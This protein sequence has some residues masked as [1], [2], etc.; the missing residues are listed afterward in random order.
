VLVKGCRPLAGT[1]LLGW[2]AGRKADGLKM[3]RELRDER[4]MRAA[5]VR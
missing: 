5:E 4:A 3:L 2:V 1:T